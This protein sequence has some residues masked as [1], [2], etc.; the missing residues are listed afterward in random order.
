[1]LKGIL[2]NN[3]SVYHLITKVKLG[4]NS[5]FRYELCAS[6]INP[7]SSVLDVCAGPGDLKNYLPAS[8]KYESLEYSLGF[9][10]KLNKNGIC[11]HKINL[12]NFNTTDL[13]NTYD[14]AV[15]IISLCSFKTAALAKIINFMKEKA[16]KVIIIE[17]VVLEKNMLTS[18]FRKYLCQK[19]GNKLRSYLC[20]NNNLQSIDLF[21]EKEFIEIM[22]KHHFVT[23][24][25]PHGY[26]LATYEQE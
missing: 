8:V 20:Y 1:M 3:V 19:L 22:H 25:F 24:K 16:K 5:S 26:I 11:N 10:N 13:P 18:S 9:V 7:G 12:H 4:K 23:Q 6:H 17:E 15:M 2:Y 14:I 21:T